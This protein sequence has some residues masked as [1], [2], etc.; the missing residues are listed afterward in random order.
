VPQGGMRAPNKDG[1]RAEHTWTVAQARLGRRPTHCDSGF[2]LGP[3]LHNDT[4]DRGSTQSYS[5]LSA[6]YEG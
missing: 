2:W 6:R 3:W 5:L 4:S 1:L